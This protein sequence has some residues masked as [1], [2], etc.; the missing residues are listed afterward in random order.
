M[1]RNISRT[2]C[3]VVFATLSVLNVA[4]VARAQE[5]CSNGTLRGSYGFSFTGE[6]PGEVGN[7]PVAGVGRVTYDGN[8]NFEAKQTIS[9]GGSSFSF[10]FRGTYSVDADCTGTQTLFTVSGEE[11]GHLAIVIIDHGQEVRITQTDPGVTLVGNERKQF[12]GR[13]PHRRN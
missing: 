9:F 6:A 10:K 4:T 1:K 3:A 8:G 13:P 11:F 2:I 12:S 5:E 7:V